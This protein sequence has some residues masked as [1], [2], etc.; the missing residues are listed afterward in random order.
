VATSSRFSTLRE[1]VELA[2]SESRTSLL[3]IGFATNE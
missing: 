2:S 3:W 1:L